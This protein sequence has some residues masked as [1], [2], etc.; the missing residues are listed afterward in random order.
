MEKK[1]YF[2]GVDSIDT[3][4]NVIDT[5]SF[6][7]VVDR[8]T[9]QI[10]YAHEDRMSLGIH[11]NK[12]PAGA[13]VFF[14]GAFTLQETA[15]IKALAK[16]DYVPIMQA[17]SKLV[18]KT[19][20]DL[21]KQNVRTTYEILGAQKTATDI[22]RMKSEISKQQVS[23]VQDVL[24][25]I[26]EVPVQPI[27]IPDAQV[28]QV[29]QEPCKKCGKSKAK[30]T[31]TCPHCGWTDWGTIIPLLVFGFLFLS[32]LHA[33]IQLDGSLFWAIIF[34]VIGA[35][36]FIYGIVETRKALKFRNKIKSEK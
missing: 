9:V 33:I 1:T 7:T 30:I 18:T 4:L 29:E 10:K 36:S 26:K 16:Y 15:E 13:I 12:D 32:V 17:V 23:E 25:T 8:K 11:P 20:V 31:Y 21:E 34:G 22:N 6:F 14:T 24:G 2:L 3:A 5:L 27:S 19:V 35:F 28:S